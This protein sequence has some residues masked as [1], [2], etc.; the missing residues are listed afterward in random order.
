[1]I[2]ITGD[3]HGNVTRLSMDNFPEQKT[4]TDQNKNYVI[5]CGD[6]GLVWNYL[7]ETSSEKYWLN[8][9]ENKKFTTL[10]VDGNHGATRC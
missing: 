9:L 6:F 7:T 3:T 4:F 10:F 1:M 2:Y 8:W 5:I